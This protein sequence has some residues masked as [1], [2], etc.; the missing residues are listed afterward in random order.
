MSTAP[1]KIFMDQGVQNVNAS[2]L[3]NLVTSL[4]DPTTAYN[5]V[6]TER[7]VAK[8]V[9]HNLVFVANDDTKSAPVRFMALEGLYWI[10]Q[11]PDDT[12][13]QGELFALVQQLNESFSSLLDREAERLG[14][15]REMLTVLLLRCT[16]YARMKAGDALAQL[17]GNDETRLVSVLVSIIQNRYYER[18]I[19]HTCFRFLYELSTP[20]SYF[21]SQEGALLETTK[22]TAFQGKLTHLVHV[23][24][25]DNVFH[26]IFADL[27]SRWQGSVQDLRNGLGSLGSISAYP[28]AELSSTQKEELMHWGVMLRY[29]C[30]MVQNIADFCGHPQTVKEIQQSFMK[31]YQHFLASVVVPYIIASVFT[32]TRS[33]VPDSRTDATTPYMNAAVT[34]LKFMRFVLYRSGADPEQPLVI[35]LLALTK[36]L[37]R[38]IKVLTQKHIGMLVLIFTVETLCNI[39]AVVVDTP[40]NL[41]AEF[42][43]LLTA[44]AQDKSP[45]VP[46]VNY[47]LAQGFIICFSQEDSTYCETNNSST[48]LLHSKFEA[49]E[50]ALREDQEAFE[51]VRRLEEQ[52]EALQSDIMQLALGHLIREMSSVAETV[53]ASLFFGSLASPPDVDAPASPMPP[54]KES[55]K[56]HP[57][58]FCCQLTG[59]LMREPVVLKNG[60]HFEYDA[61]QSVIDEMGHIDPISGEA[62]NESIDINAALQQKISQYKVDRAAKA[63]S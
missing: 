13:R 24:Q 7:S 44:V 62:L 10:S 1:I 27:T 41:S 19:T 47:S 30:V 45:I 54:K 58:E 51:S 16:G 32:Y 23:L 20:I 53:L 21:Q 12:F 28:S 61:L 46:G 4:R 18:P 25:R 60:H 38:Q 48:T 3:S 40:I 11:A 6:C 33:M 5:L 39:N 26:T 56:K 59:K 37:T 14:A 22:I 55:K 42:D 50:I 36:M 49:E 8:A 34:A 29:I 52:L 35:S 43:G 57:S 2:A 15:Q 9:A 63:S 17:C 31:K